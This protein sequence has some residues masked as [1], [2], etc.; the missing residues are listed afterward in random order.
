[1]SGTLILV[2]LAIIAVIVMLALALR[3]SRKKED[4]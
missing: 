2:F 1:M 3:E 4:S